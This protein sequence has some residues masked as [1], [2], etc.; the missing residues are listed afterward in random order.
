MCQCANVIVR[1]RW[2]PRYP[3]DL[4]LWCML[5]QAGLEL[6]GGGGLGGG[7]PLP[8]ATLDVYTRRKQIFAKT[9]L[10]CSTLATAV[11]FSFS[12]SFGLQ[13]ARENFPLPRTEI[14]KITFCS[15][16]IKSLSFAVARNANKCEI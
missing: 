11:G 6:H 7:S 9:H 13:P 2:F 15:L 10:D 3:T 1:V 4:Q 8:R 14:A 12:F 5:G 16:F